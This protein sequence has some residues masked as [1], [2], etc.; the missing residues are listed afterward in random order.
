LTRSGKS[1]WLLHLILQLLRL[2]KSMLVIDPH[3]KLY[4]GILDYLAI[5][6]IARPVLLFDPSNELR[7]VGFNPFQ[8]PYEDEGR[9]VMIQ[10]RTEAQ[11][12]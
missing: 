6:S 1:I 10:P 2:G 3:F 8:T 4:R 9:K 5:H 12:Y 7:I 11:S